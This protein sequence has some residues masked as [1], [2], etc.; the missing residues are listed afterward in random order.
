M[1]LRLRVAEPTRGVDIGSK[2]EIYD[3]LR[4]FTNK[5]GAAL[6][7]SRETIELIGLT[8]RILV[9]HDQA[10]VAEMPAREATE[11]GILDAAL[12]SQSLSTI[13]GQA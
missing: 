7:L 9:V 11:H 1:C 4:S 2:S 10:I 6:V 8:D 3:L 12:N 5:G 13:E